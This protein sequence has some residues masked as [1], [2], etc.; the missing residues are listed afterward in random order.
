MTMGIEY[1]V[2]TQEICEEPFNSRNL[3]SE[4]DIEESSESLIDDFT[5]YVLDE[6]RYENQDEDLVD[7]ERQ[8]RSRN[9]IRKPTRYED[10]IMNAESFLLD[11]RGSETYEEATE[12]VERHKWIDAMKNEMN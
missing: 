6:D 1:G 2:K 4:D 10:Y 9:E 12:C 8:F 11:Y 7:V 3:Q 5:N